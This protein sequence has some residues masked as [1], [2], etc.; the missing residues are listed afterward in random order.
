MDPPDYGVVPEPSIGQVMNPF[1]DYRPLYGQDPHIAKI[2]NTYLL[3]QSQDEE[4]ITISPLDSLQS[5][6]CISTMVVWDDPDERQVWAPELH[7]INGLWYIYYAAS[8]GDNKNHRTYVLQAPHPFGPYWKLG[9]IG[10]DKWGIDMTVFP[11]WD[12]NC[13]AVWSGWENNGDEFPQNL[14]IARMDSPW[15]INERIRLSVPELDWEKSVSPILE[16]PQI[17]MQGDK[18]SILY[19]GNASWKQEYSTGLLTLVG[20]DPRNPGDWEKRSDPLI[21]N[22]GHGCVVDDYFIYHRKMSTFPGWNDREIRTMKLEELG[23]AGS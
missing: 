23:C 17:W 1:S 21:T 6:R 22:A 5:P 13:Y 12:G 11:W 3:C 2:N 9:Q 20:H 18:L 4:R 16:G 8:D 15:E 14:Y 19:S 7:F 10:L